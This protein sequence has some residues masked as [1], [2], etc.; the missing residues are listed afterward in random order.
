MS[1]STSASSSINCGRRGSSI[2]SLSRISGVT[3][4]VSL[5]QRPTVW[6]R[7]VLGM[8][9][10]PGK[11]GGMVAPASPDLR[12]AAAEGEEDCQE[13]AEPDAPAVL[14]CRKVRYGRGTVLTFL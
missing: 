2:G 12:S 1:R 7:P 6:V 10:S 14:G 9:V 3:E 4:V 5:V 8:V 11:S 13:E